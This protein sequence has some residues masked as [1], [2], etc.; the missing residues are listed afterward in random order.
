MSDAPHGPDA[1]QGPCDPDPKKL[2]PALRRWLDEVAEG[3]DE[4]RTVL[5]RS[6]SPSALEGGSPEL[7]EI[8]STGAQIQSSGPGSATVVV[9]PR[10]LSRLTHLKSITA[11][12]EPRTLDLK[13][14]LP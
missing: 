6:R 1:T 2:S 8:E 3:S 14:Q 10:S 4:R 5:L 13:P 7:Q 9:T 11:I 12:N